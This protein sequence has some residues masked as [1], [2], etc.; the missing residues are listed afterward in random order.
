MTERT[1][2][3]VD[4]YLPHL[5][6]RVWRAL[7]DPDRLARWLMPNDFAPVVGH[8]FTFNTDPGPGFDGIVHCEVLA[9]EHERL[10]QLAWRSA[11]LDTTVMWLLQAEGRGTRLFLRHDGFDPDDPMQRHAL[12]IMGGGWQSHI[13]RKLEAELADQFDR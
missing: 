8:R 4:Q 5:P 9:M 6:A 7:T 11:A 13:M 12:T 1:A 3:E 2:I 10:L